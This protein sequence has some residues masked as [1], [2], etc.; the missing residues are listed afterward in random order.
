MSDRPKRLE[1]K[2]LVFVWDGG[3]SDAALVRRVWGNIR[4]NVAM[5]QGK[6]LSSTSGIAALAVGAEAKQQTIDSVVSIARADD[7]AAAIDVSNHT[8]GNV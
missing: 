5:N 2:G 4:E 7:F 3:T 6:V 1:K 8:H